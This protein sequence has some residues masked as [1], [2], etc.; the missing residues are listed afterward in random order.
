MKKIISLALMVMMCF[1]VFAG[2]KKEAASTTTVK[3]VPAE[4]LVSKSLIDPNKDW[5]K[6]DAMI[7]QIKSETDY[8]KRTQLMH[9]AEDVLM[10]NWC[11]LPIYY[12]NDV[13]MQKPYVSGLYANA[14]ATKFF[15]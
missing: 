14:F 3:V 10:A 6:Y 11:V 2:G 9:E 13:Y 8:A 5:A 12:Y 7:K 4:E 1:C 15:M